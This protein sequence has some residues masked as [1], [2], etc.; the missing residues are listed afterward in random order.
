MDDR[1][2][3]SHT[4]LSIHVI[5][6][7]STMKRL[8]SSLLAVVLILSGCSTEVDNE[9]LTGQ[10]LYEA[11]CAS[12]HKVNGTG[13]FLEAIPANRNTALSEKEIIALILGHDS[14]AEKMP[15]F[16]FLTADQAKRV[17]VYLKQEL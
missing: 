4:D 12:C 14:R 16:N 15:D 17:A 1:S 5:R 8:F 9:T 11:Y 7:N 2:G 6:V 13:S 3:W 10:Q